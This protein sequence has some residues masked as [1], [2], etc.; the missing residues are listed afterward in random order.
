MFLLFTVG[1]ASAATFYLTDVND[2]KY[3]GLIKIK[4]TYDGN[5]ITVQDVSSALDSTSNVD[6]SDR[7][8]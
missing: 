3:D 1:S 5:T 8:C 7:D 4:V 6:V 2:N